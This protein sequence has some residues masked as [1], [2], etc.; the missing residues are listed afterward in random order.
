LPSCWPSTGSSS[1]SKWRWYTRIR[2]PAFVKELNDLNKALFDK[3]KKENKPHAF[4][5]VMTNK[6]QNIYY[7]AVVTL[8]PF[9]DRNDFKESVIAFASEAQFQFRPV[10]SFMTRAQEILA[11][12]FH[13]QLADPDPRRDRLQK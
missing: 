10:D 11:R 5:Q 12:Q 7:V 3:A 4:V 1:Q 2:E 9:A 13:E 8:P 6:P